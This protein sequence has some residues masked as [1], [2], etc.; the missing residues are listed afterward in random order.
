MKRWLQGLFVSEIVVIFLVMGIFKM[1]PDRKI[2]A[3]I[4]GFLFV[5]LGSAIFVFG[6]RRSEFRRTASFYV[7]TLFLLLLAA[8]MFLLRILNWEANFNDLSFLGIPAQQLHQI[9]S[10]FYVGLMM[11]TAIDR[12]RLVWQ[13]QMTKRSSPN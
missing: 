5:S 8:P 6:L 11:A 10:Y 13:E 9:S 2:A 12:M 1:I 4:A 7:G 3:V